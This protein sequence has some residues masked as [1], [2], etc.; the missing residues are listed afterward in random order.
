MKAIYDK[1]PEQLKKRFAKIDLLILDFDGTLTDNKVYT[2]A[3]G[4]ETVMADRGDGLGL[5]FIR[6]YAKVDVIILSRETDKVTAARARKLKIEC[7][8]GLSSKVESFRQAIAH[9]HLTMQQ[10]CYMGNDL[11][12][13]E[14]MKEAG[15]AV[16]VADSYEQVLAVADYITKHNGGHGAV[17]EICEIIMYAKKVHPFP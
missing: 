13:I 5:E 11:N 2:N 6:K 3:K 17:R 7:K 8:H 4:E 14:C 12:D 9:R 15:L 1:L 10:V 16:A